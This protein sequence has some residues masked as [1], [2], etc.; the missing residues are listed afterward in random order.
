MN[1]GGVVAI[2]IYSACYSVYQV[3][4]SCKEHYMCVHGRSYCVI[5]ILYFDFSLDMPNC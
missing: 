4:C 3:S 2:P 1:T 5:L